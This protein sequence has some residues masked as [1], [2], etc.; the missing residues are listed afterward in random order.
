MTITSVLASLGLRGP[1]LPSDIH[2]EA[3]LDLASVQRL[4]HW[5]SYGERLRFQVPADR[6][7]M[8]G[9]LRYADHGH[10]FRLALAEGPG[11]LSAFYAS[12]QP[13]DLCAA[14]GVEATTSADRRVPAWEIPWIARRERKPP[15]GEKGLGAEHGLSF[16][17]PCSAAK[18]ELECRRLQDVSLSITRHGYQPDR[19]G[20]IDGYFMLDDDGGYRYFVRGGKH[21]VAALVHAG[22]SSIAVA[23]KPGW[24]RAIRVGDAAVWPLVASGALSEA[25]ARAVFAAYFR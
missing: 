1:H 10:P 8:Q 6:L 4:L 17:G 13:R 21:R 12:H 19:H 22:A 18:V 5:G 14:H 16:Y 23:F 15:P 24:P 11:A 25:S 9:G 7:V 2:E 3:V 20:D